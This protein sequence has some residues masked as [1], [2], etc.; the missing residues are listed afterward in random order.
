[1]LALLLM[2]SEPAFAQSGANIL[3]IVNQNS[4]DSKAIVEYYAR[5][6]SVPAQNHCSIRAVTAETIDRRVYDEQI[7]KPVRDCLV[8]GGLTESI[9]YLVTTL[10]VP[11]RIDGDGGRM[12]EMAAVDSELT[13][14]YSQIK[15]ATINLAG[16]LRNP[17]F[18]AGEAK[19]E[20]P[21]FPMYLVTR[22]AAYDRAG[23][24]RLID[25]ALRAENRGKF[26]IDLMNPRDTTQG[27]GWLSA[28]AKQL[29]A[30][31]VVL[32]TSE[33]VLYDQTDVIAYASWGSN[34]P[35][36][37]GR[38]L[39]FRWLP[40]AIMTEYVSTNARTFTRPPDSWDIGTSWTDSKQHWFKSPQSMVADYLQEGAT[41]AGGHVYEPYLTSCPRPDILLPAYFRGRN[42]AEA[43]YLSI[44]AL[45]WQNIV[46]GDPLCR[47]GR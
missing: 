30:N 17:F 41:G 47:L 19:F 4:P 46:V 16:P 10:G 29:P 36:R 18:E 27:N 12:T 26:V 9:L 2:A 25:Q 45:S 33:R 1:M 7:A 3:L 15:G 42:L 14:L 35:E 6:R 28:A 34:D 37:R 43:F 38:F 32:E 8:K 21:R 11:L 22:L 20:H 5:R 13:L 40:G 39:H 24:F 23:V 31:R 44:P